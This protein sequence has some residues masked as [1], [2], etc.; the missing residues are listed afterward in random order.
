ML[1]D[2]QRP[3]ARKVI[4]VLQDA[5]SR[6]PRGVLARLVPKAMRPPLQT[7]WLLFFRAI[8]LTTEISRPA[9]EESPGAPPAGWW[10]ALRER[11]A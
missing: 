5:K 7:Y 6:K 3:P 11:A 4:A 9:P 2:K 8:G 1:V 10:R